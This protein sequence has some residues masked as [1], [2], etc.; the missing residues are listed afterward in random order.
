MTRL[1]QLHLGLGAFHR[2][3]QAVYLQ[4][5]HDVG[6]KRWCLAAGNLRADTTGS[7]AALVASQGRYTLETV[8]PAGERHRQSIHALEEVV[9]WSSGLARLVELGADAATRIVSFTVTEAG[10]YLGPGDVLDLDHVELRADLAEAREG[11]VHAHAPTLY[12]A[13]TALL[14]ARRA[15]GSGPLTLLCCDNLRHNGQRSRSGLLQFLE[16]VGDAGLLSWVRLHTTQPDSM[17]DRITPRPA[18]GTAELMAEHWLQWV[19]QRD[20][21]ADGRPAWETVG[22]QLVDDVQP[23]EEAKI[24]ILNATH[25]LLAWAGALRGCRF[26]HEAVTILEVRGMAHGFITDEVVPCLQP[27]PL[28]LPAYR[29]A[30]LDRFANEALA[31]TCQ[32]VAA[33]SMAKIP[34][35]ILPTLRERMAQGGTL[36]AG[37]RLPALYLD[38]LRQWQAGRLPFDY[39]DQALV[40]AQMRAVLAA[41]DPVAAFCALPQ[42]WG[43]LAAV[44]GF[45]AAVRAA[46]D[47]WAVK[48]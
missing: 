40:P 20:G 6:D 29:D 46:G 30:V 8:T 2:A 45:T 23:F 16:A 10:Y 5:L 12:G 1:R 27:S 28:D 44:P 34:G 11:H 21:F 19:L 15:A 31:D 26:I 47:G 9:P 36:E 33:D 17:V 42:L 4:R 41:P 32:R 48:S 35:F 43:E 13:L 22:A 14:R 38:F 25:S 37:A 24:R 18:P 3:H 7:E 39:Q